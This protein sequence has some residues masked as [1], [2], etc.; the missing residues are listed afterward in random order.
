MKHLGKF[1][2]LFICFCKT[3]YGDF[4][5]EISDKL[6]LIIEET[7]GIYGKFDRV[8]PFPDQ[9][10]S[11]INQIYLV[12]TYRGETFVLK[13]ENPHWKSQKTINEVLT[14]NY[15]NHNTSILVPKVLAYEN[16]I[17]HSPIDREYI[18]MTHMRGSPLNHEFKRIYS[19][20]VIYRNVLEQLATIL[21]EL[22]QLSFPIIG[23]FTYPDD[24]KL[25]CPVDL[26]N[27]GYNTP[28]LSFSEYA[29]RW[30]SYF[31]QEM[32]RLK[33]SGHQNSQYF[34]KYIP[35]VQQLLYSPCLEKLDKDREIF[36]FSHQDFVMK[37]ILIEDTTITAILDWE[38]SGTAPI[39][40]EAKSG[41]DFLL[42]DEDVS[43]FN[44]M[45]EEKGIFNFFDPPSPARQIFYEA[46]GELY[47]L[48]SCYEWI[49]G[50]LEHSAK[51]LDQKLEQR[52][53]RT[54]KTFDME[55]YIFEITTL[56]DKHFLEINKDLL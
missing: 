28:C 10:G 29:R 54:L 1:L 53:V 12:Y 34:E 11:F 43:I 47:T 50:K 55:S 20:P 48:I 45:L 31:L 52:R 17:D 7:N 42:T 16:V 9:G 23:S 44:S 40:F 26:I 38:W 18:L 36:L 49:E 5:N 33:I 56:L 8:I 27:L 24:L 19:N 6:S 22:K 35:Q 51:F 25:Q 32:K 3:L 21:G 46:M 14:L 41:C 15:L 2:V 39:E 4:C 37:N 13:V 30:L